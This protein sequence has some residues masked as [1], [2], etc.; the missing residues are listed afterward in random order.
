MVAS[1]RPSPTI[2]EDRPL[3]Y[4]FNVENYVQMLEAGILKKDDRVELLCGEI[5]QMS[6]IGTR[7]Q[8]C[9]NHLTQY[10]VLALQQ[11]AIVSVQNAV[12]L[13]RDSQPQPDLAIL[14]PRLDF[15][16]DRYPRPEDIL[17]L[18]EIADSTLSFDRD[19]KIPLYAR[20]G[21]RETWLVDLNGSCVEVYCDPSESGYRTKQTFDPGDRL[22]PTALPNISV[23]VDRIFRP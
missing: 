10:L 11:S 1:E 18:I 19:I 5:L 12:R 4:R 6:P 23:A 9:V 8:A 15:Y 20:A 14:E 21:V 3:P 22:A 17:L 16:A 2:A 7:H 13:T